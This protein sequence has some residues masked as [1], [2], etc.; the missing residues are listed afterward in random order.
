VD[1]DYI[2]S[3]FTKDGK[4]KFLLLEVRDGHTRLCQSEQR[5]DPFSM[6]C[7]PICTFGI[8]P[9]TQENYSI[10]KANIE[11]VEGWELLGETYDELPIAVG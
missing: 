6:A 9:A 5:G 7:T 11:T 4:F 1:R 10:V 8:T 2:K 3:I